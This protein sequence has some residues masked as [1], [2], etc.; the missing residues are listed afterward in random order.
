MRVYCATYVGA[1]I[2]V[3]VC[4]FVSMHAMPR[5]ACVLVRVGTHVRV[6]VRPFLRS[7]QIIRY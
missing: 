7:V 6:S 2:C 1:R 3:R 5:G 4:V